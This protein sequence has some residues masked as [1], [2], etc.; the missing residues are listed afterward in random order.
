MIY[1]R[2]S[3]CRLSSASLEFLLPLVWTSDSGPNPTQYSQAVILLRAPQKGQAY[4]TSSKLK[5]GGV[6]LDNDRL[7]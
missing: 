5:I 3:W 2:R 6:T 1:K 7:F 4:C